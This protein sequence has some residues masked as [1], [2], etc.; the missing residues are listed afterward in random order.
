MPFLSNIQV[1]PKWFLKQ[2]SLHD[3]YLTDTL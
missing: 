1:L 3:V 2:K